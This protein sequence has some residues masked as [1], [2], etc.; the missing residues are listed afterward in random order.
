MN[1]NANARFFSQNVSEQC[2]LSTD[3]NMPKID[4]NHVLSVIQP[5]KMGGDEIS[6]WGKGGE[7]LTPTLN[8]QKVP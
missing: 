3:I 2:P 1:I 8:K 4:K 6:R 7:D 5:Q